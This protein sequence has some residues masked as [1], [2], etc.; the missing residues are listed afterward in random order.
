MNKDFV[1][2]YLAKREAA[3]PKAQQDLLAEEI[4]KIKKAANSDLRGLVTEAQKNLTKNG[5]QVFVVKDLAAASLKIKE[6]IGSVG[7]VVKAKSNTLDKLGLKEM[8]NERLTETDLGAYIVSKI[9]KDSDHPVLPSIDLTAEEVAL[10]FNAKTGSEYPRT[11]K[12]LVDVLKQ[13]IKSKILTAE[14]GL[15]GANAVM[16]DGQ[17]MLLENEGNISLITR[18]PKTH[19]AVCGVEK[20]IANANEAVKVA[21]AAAVWG[22]GQSFPTYVSFISGPSKTADIE[23]ELV[24]G[25]QGAQEV[26]L[27]LVEGEVYERLGTDTESMNYCIHCGACYNLCP[28]WNA[29]AGMPKVGQRDSSFNCTLC[30]NCT[31]NCPVKIEWQNIVRIYRDRYNKDG[32]ETEHNAQMIK[33]IKQFGNPFGENV[34]GK[35]PDELF[36]C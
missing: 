34:D 26:I 17:I 7:G 21:K 27:I 4:F 30:Q 24:T 5:V 3:L 36:C 23:N 2:N 14:V 12:A 25:V 19:I 31:Y 9:G 16:A 8:L 1:Y 15:T 20:V 6:L 13:E 35:T 11:A 10:G 28:T 22:T 29:G 18:L 32:Q 33:N